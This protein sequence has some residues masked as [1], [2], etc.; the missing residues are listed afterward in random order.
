MLFRYRRELGKSLAPELPQSEVAIK[1]SISALAQSRSMFS[2]QR[3]DSDLIAAVE[4]IVAIPGKS[5]VLESTVFE[6]ND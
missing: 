2:T 5:G 6:H 1:F 4:S 3:P